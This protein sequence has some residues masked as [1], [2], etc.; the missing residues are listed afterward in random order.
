MR[1]IQKKKSAKTQ[2]PVEPRLE[3]ELVSPKVTDPLG[4]D[5]VEIQPPLEPALPW[6]KRWSNKAY[7]YFFKYD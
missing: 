6:Y 4:K 1:K 2:I 7:D 5:W 3:P